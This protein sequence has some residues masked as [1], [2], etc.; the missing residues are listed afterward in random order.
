MVLAGRLHLYWMCSHVFT[1]H[2]HKSDTYQNG[3]C[4]T[5]EISSSSET[6]HM[7]INLSVSYLGYLS[8]SELFK[9][10]SMWLMQAYSNFVS[11]KNFK[12]CSGNVLFPVFLC[13]YILGRSDSENVFAKRKRFLQ[14][15]FISLLI[16]YLSIIYSIHT[17]CRP[18]SCVS[19]YGLHDGWPSAH[20]ATASRWS[21]IPSRLCPLPT[22][23]L[24]R[25]SFVIFLFLHIQAN[26]IGE[27]CH[28]FFYIF[29]IWYE[30][31]WR[32]KM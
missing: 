26:N 13:A 11:K 7:H 10:N 5:D 1:Q 28:A 17:T 21:R 3:R 32:E 14:F 25:T 22:S 30:L 16:I 6:H 27:S 31:V 23:R 8:P 29:P 12:F 24:L 18:I 19:R 15:H 4:S 2:I 20:D 9:C